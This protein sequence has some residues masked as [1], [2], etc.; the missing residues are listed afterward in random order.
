MV[1]GHWAVVGVVE[2]KPIHADDDV[3]G[4]SCLVGVGA[5]PGA[6]GCQSDGDGVDVVTGDDPWPCPVGVKL[7][8][9]AAGAPGREEPN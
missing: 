3:S 5:R 6:V 1:R 4:A 7:F 9:S 8:G 2:F